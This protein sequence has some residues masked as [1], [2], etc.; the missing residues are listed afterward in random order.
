MRKSNLKTLT[1]SKTKNNNEFR[2]TVPVEGKYRNERGKINNSHLSP[3]WR[4]LSSSE[5]LNHRTSGVFLFFSFHFSQTSFIFLIFS[6]T[7]IFNKL[8]S[9]QPVVFNSGQNNRSRNKWH[10]EKPKSKN[11]NISFFAFGTL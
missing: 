5:K 8:K 6:C 1:F 7:F 4:H 11:L 2:P 10:C 3:I 9:P